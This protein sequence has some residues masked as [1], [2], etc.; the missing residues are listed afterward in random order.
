MVGEPL[1]RHDID[2]RR[3]HVA[4]A[5]AGQPANIEYWN[6]QVNA[7]QQNRPPAARSLQPGP[8]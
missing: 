7:W 3:E 6:G 2:D 1:Q 8:D 4:A 5:L